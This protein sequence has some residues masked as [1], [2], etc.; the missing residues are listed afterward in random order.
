[1]Y[2]LPK[3][4]EPKYYTRLISINSNNNYGI[5]RTTMIKRWTITTPGVT[6]KL[7][8]NGILLDIPI[9]DGKT[10]DIGAIRAYIRDL[11]P[12]SSE[13]HNLCILESTLFGTQISATEYYRYFPLTILFDMIFTGDL[14]IYFVLE[15]EEGEVPDKVDI[16]EEYALSE[17]QLMDRLTKGETLEDIDARNRDKSTLLE[18]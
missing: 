17:Y 8:I 6:G 7:K 15:S 3:L 4:K 5:A 1:M 9:L 18:F 16:E 11:V 10:F 2:P 14:A 13:E 12:I